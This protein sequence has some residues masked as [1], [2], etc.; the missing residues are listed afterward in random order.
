V[1]RNREEVS[2][3]RIASLVGQDG[4][5]QRSYRLKCLQ[6]PISVM[7]FAS[8]ARHSTAHPR[9]CLWHTNPLALLSASNHATAE[10]HQTQEIRTNILIRDLRRRPPGTASVRHTPPWTMSVVGMALPA[11][12]SNHMRSHD[13]L[14]GRYV[15]SFHKEASSKRRS[16]PDPSRRPIV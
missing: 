6:W 7:C 4:G 15:A 5:A 8:S 16:H 9:F 11:A 14:H 13:P 10:S 1:S 2:G 3:R 12:R